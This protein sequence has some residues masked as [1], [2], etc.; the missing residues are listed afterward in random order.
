MDLPEPEIKALA[1]MLQR[2]H[3]DPG[4]VV[5]LRGDPGD[6]LY[7]ISSGSVHVSLTSPEGKEVLLTVLGPGDFFGDL[8]LLDGQPRSADVIAS[9]ECELLVLRRVDFKRV[10]SSHPKVFE[11]L[12]G[13]MSRRLRH[14]ADLIEEVAFLDISA[15]LARLL[16]QL[17]AEPRGPAEG[18]AA[19]GPVNQTDL[20]NM[21]N[22]TRESVNK[23]LASFERQGIIGRRRRQLFIL[24]REQLR[25]LAQM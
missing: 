1:R 19:L 25:R 14:N 20:A 2:S 17:A 23:W 21:I 22:A 10:L 11:H 3:S 5:F 15:R 24:N 12:L 7:L 6:A 8:S 4:Q 13:V 9:D 18:A 16:L